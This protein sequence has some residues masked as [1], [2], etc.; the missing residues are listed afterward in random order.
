MA[1]QVQFRGG[2]TAESDAF[3]GAQ[4]ELT[5]DTEAKTIR[6]HD[7]VL[8][9]GYALARKSEIGEVAT[10]STFYTDIGVVNAYSLTNTVEPITS[11]VDGMKVRFE[12]LNTNT[13][14]STINVDGLGFKDL[15][16]LDGSPTQPD[17]ISDYVEAYYDGGSDVFKHITSGPVKTTLTSDLSVAITAPVGPQ[18]QVPDF[19]VDVVAGESYTFDATFFLG[20][21][22]PSSSTG[23]IRV[24]CTISSSPLSGTDF[25]LLSSS[26][27]GRSWSGFSS[28]E[29]FFNDVGGDGV[30]RIF[31][32]LENIPTITPV[33]IQAV[34]NLSGYYTADATETL[35]FYLEAAPENSTQP[36]DGSV[37][38]LKGSSLIVTRH[39]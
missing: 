23:T 8:T 29:S 22:T 1:I 6:V 5:V 32:D 21:D 9:G 3:L 26:G 2:D 27:A 11:Y 4:R 13:G 31:E 10:A 19:S 25:L 7:G 15:V 30:L 12:P 33:G 16:R 38:L 36:S 35:N 18:V 28:L 17:D 24:A 34:S 37:K 39:I 20:T 14:A